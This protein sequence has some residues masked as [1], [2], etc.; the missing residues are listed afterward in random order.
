MI[1]QEQ[2]KKLFDYNQ[3]TGVL[4]FRLSRG[5]SKIGEP[6]GTLL[7]NDY[8][9]TFIDCKSYYVHRIVFLHCN[10]YIPTQIDHI[11]QVKIDNRISNLRECDRH[12]NEGNTKK[13]SHNTSGFKGVFHHQGKWMVRIAGSYVGIYDSPALAAIAYDEAAIEHYGEFAGT[14]LPSFFRRSI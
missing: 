5:R 12:Q 13:R 1:T 6:V 3:E 7:T 14:N 11:N 4:S 8:L 10:G 2:V 9:R